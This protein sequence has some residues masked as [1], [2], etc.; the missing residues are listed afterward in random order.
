M[1]T[2]QTAAPMKLIHAHVYDPNTPN[3]FF[4]AKA[5]DRAELHTVSCATSDRCELY[6]RGECAARRL[7]AGCVYGRAS[8]TPGPTKRSQSCRT[9]VRER[10]AETAAVGQIKAPVDKMARVGDYIWLPYAH[11]DIVLT[12]EVNL[13]SSWRGQFI[14]AERFTAPLVATICEGHPRAIFGGEII[15]YQREDVPK[16]VNHLVEVYP[17]LAR[18]AAPMSPRLQGLM[19]TLTKVGR[20]A[21][22]W[23]LLP[24]VGLF[25]G[26][27]SSPACWRW[28]GEALTTEDSKGFPPF[29]PFDATTMRVV[30]GKDAV[31]V[32]T[33]DAQVGPDTVLVD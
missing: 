5:N 14:L 3:I 25:R 29:S 33:D 6:A 20:K 8:I 10:K 17:D 23:T 7:M 27:A 32:V 30:P 31:V 16:F 18:E 15:N 26:G 19:A 11:I 9:W 21:R 2:D 12:G 1:S 4:K 13:G 28:D 22:V 24:N